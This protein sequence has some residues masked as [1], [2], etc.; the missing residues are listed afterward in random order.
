MRYR[1]R[2]CVDPSYIRVVTAVGGVYS[3]DGLIGRIRHR[4]MK[5]D[6]STAIEL[7]ESRE[8]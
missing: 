3:S 7:L 8:G 1:S 6:A 2:C 4:R 5:G